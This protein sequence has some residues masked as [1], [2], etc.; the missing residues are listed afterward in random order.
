MGSAGGVR[1]WGRTGR[2]VGVQSRSSLAPR[3]QDPGQGGREA[4][5][6]LSPRGAAASPASAAGAAFRPTLGIKAE[7]F[8]MKFIF[9]FQKME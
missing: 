7:S 2:A 1:T 5:R 9:I 4:S 8:A 3:V 6:T